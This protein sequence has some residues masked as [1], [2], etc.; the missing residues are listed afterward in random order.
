M[1]DELT[2]YQA[3][4]ARIQQQPDPAPPDALTVRELLATFPVNG[5]ELRKLGQTALRELLA[6]LNL[7]VR[8]NHT[9][10]AVR[11]HLTLTEGQG[12]GF[13][14]CGLLR[15]HETAQRCNHRSFA[16]PPRSRCPP[17]LGETPDEGETRA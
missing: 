7:L 15:R 5:V 17:N 1:E 9:R 10:H 13:L 2:G 6:S 12:D 11:L 14:E 8:Y 3:S 16:S 4:L